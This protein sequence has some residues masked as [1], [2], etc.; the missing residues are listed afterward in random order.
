MVPD[1]SQWRHSN[2]YDYFDDLGVSDLAWEYL[3]RN[4]E[5]QRDYAQ[6]IKQM[7]D[8]RQAA[9]LFRLRWG[10]RFPRSSEPERP[11]RAGILDPRS[12]PRKSSADYSATDRWPRRRSL[13]RV[14]RERLAAWHGRASSHPRRRSFRNPCRAARRSYHRSTPRS[15]CP[16]RRRCARTADRHLAFLARATF[17]STVR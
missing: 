14:R 12:G 4:V 16:A 13:G 10:L 9:D 6:T 11:R 5:Y 15:A 1:A 17:S 8:L 7:D 3:R 2:Y